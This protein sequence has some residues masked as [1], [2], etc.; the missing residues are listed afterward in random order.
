[1]NSDKNVAK[2]KPTPER[3]NDLFTKLDLSGIQDWPE[4]L[5]QKVHDLMIEYQHSFALNDLELGKTSKVKHEIKLSNPVAFK[6]RYCQIPPHEFDEVQ[7]HLQDMLK[8]GAIRKSVS[9]WASPVVLVRKKDSSL[10]FCI[11]L[12]KLNSRMIKDAYS[13]PRIEESLDC[14][15][16]AIIFTSLDLK[17]GYWQV[18]MEESSIPYT[19]FTVGPL[20]FYKC[21]HMPF[22]LTNAPAMFQCLME[23]CLGDYHLK[24]CIIYL[25]D[26]IIFSKTPEEHISRLCKVFQKLD[27]AGLCLKPNKCEFFKDRLEYLG[28]V[29]SSKGIET[30]PKK[31]AVILN[32]PLPRNITQIRSFLGFCNYYRKFIKG[33]AQVARPL[34]QLLT[35][36]N[37]KKKTNEVEWTE[38]CEQAFNKLKKI[39]SD[40]PIL[41]YADYSKC[42]KVC[43]DALEQGLGAVLYQDQV[44]GTTR[45]IAYASRNLSKFEKRYHS[46]KL[47]FLALRWSVCERFHE[48]LYGGKF[49]V[50][51][52]NNPLMYI[53]TTAKLDATGQ[54]W[55]AS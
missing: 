40:T 12:H 33:Y 54:W 34:Y 21:V 55:V 1:M 45:V 22:G 9:L 3:L 8:V 51:T 20:G 49:Q 10:R 26:I 25:D 19:A 36:E 31:I 28:H 6:D 46:S 11:D 7:S 5:Q 32:W 52:D 16:G 38:Q 50:Y 13:L 4:D 53:L 39:C 48:Y 23:S 43:T 37:A 24:Y 41:A 2:P 15:N 44:D 47:E 27:E 30:N 35:G 17:A 14:L 29:V 18:E 42:F